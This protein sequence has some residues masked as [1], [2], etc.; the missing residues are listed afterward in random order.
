MAAYQ[1]IAR[2]RGREVAKAITGSL[3]KVVILSL[4]SYTY[5]M[6]HTFAEV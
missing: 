5:P 1:E 3:P 4:Y 2:Q 6:S